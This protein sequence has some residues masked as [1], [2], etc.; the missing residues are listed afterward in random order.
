MNKEIEITHG[1]NLH[2]IALWLAIV[3]LV[4]AM[5][6]IPVQTK[7][8]ATG[9]PLFFASIVAGIFSGIVWVV[10]LCIET[11]ARGYHSLWGLL[12]LIPPAILIY[13]FVFK[14]KFRKQEKAQPATAPYSEPAT[15]SPQG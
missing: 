12:L 4:L 8:I 11:K 9:T 3:G 2:K 13:P 10:A 1:V 14:D 7:L 15:R 5:L 6:T